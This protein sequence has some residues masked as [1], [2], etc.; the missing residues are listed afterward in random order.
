MT[1]VNATAPAIYLYK[2]GK[3]FI[4]EMNI[5]GI[6]PISAMNKL[7]GPKW[8]LG[9]LEKFFIG[10]D[11]GIDIY[12]SVQRGVGIGGTVLGGTLTLAKDIGLIYVNKGIMYASTSIGTLICP[13]VGTAI[14]FLV[15]GAICIYT[16]IN[17]GNWLDQLIDKIAK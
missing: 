11:V 8:G 17:L 16:N 2:Y 14:G 6:N 1:I 7:P 15:G 13:G 3:T 12:D 5:F 9:G 10:L 4:D